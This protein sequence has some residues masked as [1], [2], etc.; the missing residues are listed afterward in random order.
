M[1]SQGYY[2][3]LEVSLGWDSNQGPFVTADGVLGQDL[4][5]EPSD[6]LENLDEK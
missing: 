6:K 3:G 1:T 5:Q 4:N 2:V